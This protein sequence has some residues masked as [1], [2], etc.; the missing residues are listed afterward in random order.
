MMAHPTTKTIGP[1]TASVSE[2]GYPYWTHI[3]HRDGRIGLGHED[4]RDLLYAVQRI[5][6]YLDEKKV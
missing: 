6:A 3:E 1:I 4:A 2:P 5:V